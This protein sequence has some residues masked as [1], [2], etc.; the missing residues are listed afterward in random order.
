MKILAVIIIASTAALRAD[1]TSPAVAAPAAPVAI[2]EAT[3]AHQGYPAARYQPLWTKS[4]FA[5]ETPDQDTTESAEYSLVGVAELDG[6][7]YASL[8]DKQNQNHLLLASDKPINGLTLNSITRKPGGDT[9]AT[10]TQNGQQLTLK[11][12]A[13]AANAGLQG[14]G[15]LTGIVAPNIPMPNGSMPQSTRPLIRIHRPIIRLPQRIQNAL[16]ALQPG[17]QPGN[18]PNP[19]PGQPLPPTS[20]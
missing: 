10:L 20:Q 14:G 2:D 11:L 16:N 1:D 3:V 15:G 18:Q 9:F 4:P 7:A 13:P 12:E 8:I 19:P 5:V 6:V 17:N